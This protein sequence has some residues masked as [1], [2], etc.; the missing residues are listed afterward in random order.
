MTKD[1][2]S[3]L[4][5]ETGRRRKAV[6]LD[7]DGTLIQD[8]DYLQDPAQVVLEQGAAEAV[9]RLNRNDFAVILV[10]NQSG[11]ARGYF[12]EEDVVAVHQRLGELLAAENARLDAMY[13]CPHYPEGIV[14]EYRQSCGCRK[15][16]TGMFQRASQEWGIDL[17]R[18]YMIGDKLT[19]IEAA[20]N[21]GLAGVLVRTGYGEDEWKASVRAEDTEKPDRVAMDLREAV[22]FVFWAERHLGRAE[23]GTRKGNGETCLWTSKW[24][25]V[26]FLKKCLDSHRR[27]K[28]TIVL[29][30]GVFD[31]L[32]AGHVGYL[33]AA[34]ELGD[35]LVVA[36]NSDASVRDLKGA[37]RPI[38][39]VEERVEIVSALACVDYCVVFWDR[40]VNSLLEALRPDF[41]AKGTD[42]EEASVPERGI[43]IRHGGQVRIVGPRKGWATTE[44]LGR[45]RELEKKSRVRP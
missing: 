42:Y 30:N 29:A 18:S 14:Q 27:Q 7:R 28:Q 44:L 41:Q 24:V 34:K 15:P 40:T 21:A 43:V 13:Y 25:S 31:L 5:Q 36:L 9:A 38:L 19:D 1:R 17:A 11:V 16:A 8:K 2:A 22:E 45:I 23:A 32:H 37:G 3:G 6:F 20:R 10:T 35:V 12:T 39:P 33:Q 4:L 26:P